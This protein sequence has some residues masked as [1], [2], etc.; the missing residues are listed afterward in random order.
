VWGGI[1]NDRLDGGEGDDTLWGG[2]GNDAVTYGAAA[3]AVTVDL[4]WLEEQNTYGAGW[5]T[6][7]SI[8]DLIGSA[9]GDALSGNGGANRLTGGAGGDTLTGGAGVDVFVYLALSDSILAA[10]DAITDFADGVDRI[11]VSLIDA[12]IVGSGNQAFH[13]GAT[14]G[15]VS[16]IVLAFDAA[17]NRTSVSLYV[18]G[19]TTVD[20]LIWLGGNHLALGAADFVL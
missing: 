2:D 4:S 14:A 12:N 20:A 1:G 19:D 15:H 13:L 5:D 18:N 11:D 3:A 10:T 6:L 9:F 7:L 8:E 17:S 16:D